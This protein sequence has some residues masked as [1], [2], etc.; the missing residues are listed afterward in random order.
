ME[1]EVTIEEEEA[2]A[3]GVAEE[4]EADTEIE[5]AVKEVTTEVAEVDIEIETVEKV[6]NSEEAE[7][8]EAAEEV[9]GTEEAERDHLLTWAQTTESFMRKTPGSINSCLIRKRPLSD[10]LMNSGFCSTQWTLISNSL[11]SLR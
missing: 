4:A 9:V 2:A 10:S 5:M 3:E 6:K 7:A 11:R 8:A 1:T